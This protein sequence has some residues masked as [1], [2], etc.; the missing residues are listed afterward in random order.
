[1]YDKQIIELYFPS[2]LH[3]LVSML[4]SCN[5]SPKLAFEYYCKVNANH[6]HENIRLDILYELLQNEIKLHEKSKYPLKNYLF[7]FLSRRL[8]HNLL[9]FTTDIEKDF[10]TTFMTFLREQSHQLDEWCVMLVNTLTID[11]WIEDDVTIDPWIEDDVTERLAIRLN[12]LQSKYFTNQNFTENTIPT[13]RIKLESS[14][15]TV[16]DETLHSSLLLPIN[17]HTKPLTYTKNAQKTCISTTGKLEPIAHVAND[18]L[19]IDVIDDDVITD[20]IDDGLITDFLEVGPIANVIGDDLELSMNCDTESVFV[21][22]NRVAIENIAL[23]INDKSNNSF[24]DV[25]EMVKITPENDLLK[26]LKLM[27]LQSASCASKLNIFDLII[28]NDMLLLNVMFDSIVTKPVMD[29]NG[30]L[31]RDELGFI[32]NVCKQHPKIA[33]T[34][35]F[36]SILRSNNFSKSHSDIIKNLTLNETFPKSIICETLKNL[37]EDINLRLNENLLITLESLLQSKPDLS[38]NDIENLLKHL[39]EHSNTLA[40]SIALVKLIIV[41]TKTYTFIVNKNIPLVKA[42][43]D[44]NRTFF[45]KSALKLL[46]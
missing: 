3:E 39:H 26:V 40:N 34:Q 27:K 37:F 16:G 41:I 1:M 8:Q 29:S 18:K 2:S 5:S 12:S 35:F 33:T 11:P 32:S 46:C 14:T 42:I 21:Q 17:T 4:S 13:K 38:Q 31:S 22:N 6:R 9:T 23:R 44:N 20:A 15:Q 7:F 10:T 25:L 19:I 36:S 30:P 24:E 43:L 45:K 28:K